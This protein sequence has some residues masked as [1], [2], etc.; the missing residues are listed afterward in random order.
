MDQLGYIGEER[1]LLI[2]QGAALGPYEAALTYADGAPVDLTHC[3]IPWVIRKYWNSPEAVASGT[4]EISDA[5]AG[6]YIV[7]IDGGQTGALFAGGT[8][9]EPASLGIWQADVQPQSGDPRPL[10]Y[11]PV[12]VKRDL[13]P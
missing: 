5:A 2:R 1:P 6:K 9:T 3:T 8:L 13:K 4:F 11:G 10:F 12:R 7:H